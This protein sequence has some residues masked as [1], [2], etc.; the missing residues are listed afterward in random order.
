MILRVKN[1]K[2]YDE[3]LKLMLAAMSCQIH[4]IK[5]YAFN[6]KILDILGVKL[7]QLSKDNKLKISM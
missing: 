7:D 5:N 3:E 2:L 4:E 1:K 6:M